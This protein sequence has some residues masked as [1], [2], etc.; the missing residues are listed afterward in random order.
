MLDGLDEVEPEW[1][2]DK[3]LPW[4]GKICRDYPECRYL[5]SSRPEGYP[6]GSLENLEFVQCDLLDFDK[7][8]VSEFAKHWCTAVRLARNEPEAEARREGEVDGRAIVDGFKGHLYT[9]NLARNPL[10]LSAICLV[11]YFEGG[12]L[13]KDR[14]VLYNLCVDGLLDNWDQR[15]GIRSEFGYDEKVRACREVAVAM[16]ADNRAE[17]EAPKVQDIF[18]KVLGDSQRAQKLLEHIRRRTGLLLER[19]PGVFAFAHLILVCYSPACLP[20]KISAGRPVLSIF[21]F[22]FSIFHFPLSY[23]DLCP[24]ARLSR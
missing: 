12:Q 14:A 4:F 22:H 24:L 8:Q 11:N 15:R 20:I 3:L 9:R 21:H 17:Y 6:P 1:R 7:P 13:P 18:S 2:D 23:L 5:L 10:M 16:Q 19:R